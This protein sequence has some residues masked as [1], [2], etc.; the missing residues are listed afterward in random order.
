M[1][2]T[3]V[4]VSRFISIR[5]LVLAGYPLHRSPLLYAYYRLY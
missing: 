1:R 5:R 2:I 3:V 4:D